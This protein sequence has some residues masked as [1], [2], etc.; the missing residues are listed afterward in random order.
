MLG[1]IFVMLVCIFA[2]SLMIHLAVDMITAAPTLAGWSAI[3]SFLGGLGLILLGTAFFVCLT[4][5]GK[6]AID[7][8]KEKLK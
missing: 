7:E 8:I 5:L 4:L 2:G 3:G 6:M 1:L